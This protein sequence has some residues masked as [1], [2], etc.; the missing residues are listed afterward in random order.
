MMNTP[1][2]RLRQA[3]DRGEM[4]PFIGVYD[5]FSATIAAKHF[6]GLFLSGFSFAASHYGLPDIGFIAWRDIVDLVRRIRAVLP[7]PHL[8]VDI[9][10]G[11][12]DADTA[13]YVVRELEDAGASA[14]VL[15]DQARPRMCGHFTG[16]RLLELNHYLQKLDRVLGARRKEMVVIA[17]TDACDDA[18]RIRRVK[19]F[20]AAGADAVLADG[21]R[22]FD[23]IRAI[24]RSVSKPIMF[25]QIAGGLSPRCTLSQLRELGVRL[26]NY[27][28]PCLFAAQEAMNKAMLE[29]KATDGMLADTSRGDRVGVKACTMLMQENMHRAIGMPPIDP[30]PAPAGQE[31]RV[32]RPPLPQNAQSDTM[33]LRLARL[34]PVQRQLLEQRMKK[35]PLSTTD[36]EGEIPRVDRN[37]PMSASFAQARM[38]FL[39]QLYPGDVAYNGGNIIS[40]RGEVDVAAVQ[41]AVYRIVQRHETL[42]TGFTE[43]EGEPRIQ[44]LTSVDRPVPLVDLSHLDSEAAEREL[45][46]QAREWRDAPF[47]LEQPPL[48]RFKLVKMSPSRFD[49]IFAVHHIISDRWSIQVLV[50]ELSALYDAIRTGRMGALPELGVQY[51][52]YASWQRDELSGDGLRQ[53]LEPWCAMLLPLPEPLDLP[54]AKARPAITSTSG[55]LH[56]QFLSKALAERVRTLAGS[57]SMTPF[58]LHLAAFFSLL[59]KHTQREDLVVGVPVA[60]RN[61]PDVEALIGLFVNTLP[62]R[63]RLNANMRFKELAGQV[64]ATM[65]Q[66]LGQQDVPFEKLVHEL[67]V[68]RDRSRSPLVSVMLNYHNVPVRMPAPEGIDLRVT[69]IPREKAKLDLTLTLRDEPQGLMTEYEYNTDLFEAA[70]IERFAAQYQATLE[71]VLASPEASLSQLVA[72]L[73]EGESPGAKVSSPVDAIED[74]TSNVGPCLHELVEQQVA[75][76]PDGVAVIAG[77]VTLTYRELNERGD[78][79]ASRLR[80]LGVGPDSLVGLYMKRGAEM[81]VGLL[82]IL[83]A[84]GA[85]VPL[86]PSYPRQRLAGMMSDARLSVL[87]TQ[88]GLENDTPAAVEHTLVLDPRGDVSR[89]KGEGPIANTPPAVAPRHLAYVLFTSGSTGRPKGVMIEHRAIVNH[90]LWMNERFPLTANDRVLQKTPISFDASVWEFW[91]PLIAGAAL[92]M[93][94]PDAHRDPATLV[95]EVRNHRITTLQLVPSVLAAMLDSPGLQACESLSRVYAGGEALT[96]AIVSRFFSQC[97]AQL[98]NLY[99]PTEAA[100]DA[101]YHVCT[102][103]DADGATAP[104]G[105]PITHMRALVLD[106]NAKPVANGEVGELY[107]GGAGLARGYLYQ[108]DLTAERFV[109]DPFATQPGGRLYRT[110]DRVCAEADGTLQFRGRVDHQ[111]KLRG[112]RIELGEIEALLVSHDAIRQ[113]AAVVREDRPGDQRLFAYVVPGAGLKVDEADLRDHLAHH[114][115]A[116]VLPSAFIVLEA[117]PQLPNGKIDRAALPMPSM[118][119][120]PVATGEGTRD[121]VEQVLHEI[122]CAALG[123]E[124]AGIHDDFFASGGHSLLAMRV[125]AQIRS[126]LNAEV[127]VGRLFDAPTIAGLAAAVKEI[128]AAPVSSAAPIRRAARSFN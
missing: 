46:G 64:R 33:A 76:S 61:H 75:T 18:E 86:E 3:M 89:V 1:T 39:D 63:G 53:R 58:T 78:A 66:C 91:A 25:N 92:V 59:F 118:Q 112:M 80:G 110:G 9:D 100:I 69:D 40:L 17:R 10:D 16:K 94:E 37:S 55:A 93:A 88:P 52:D 101:T 109:P 105:K 125:L 84:G 81:V 115:P 28:T 29:I 41:Q 44:I 49:L 122:W 124:S 114:L 54:F 116:A 120:A 31:Q 99:G 13:A 30:A 96:A 121:E 73:S 90:M 107:L 98:I 57:W 95:C 127:K 113:A 85:Y 6:G 77:E 12:V 103:A 72:W 43:Y 45:L 34:S 83:K 50:S 128:R 5:V 74:A 51:V 126:R 27:S 35:E 2:T 26:V 32:E 24:A 42:R 19:A 22:S 48:C 62:V 65:M 60:G 14:V 71:A 104:I 23:S 21:L 67:K 87:L 117:M 119:I 97:G 15:E 8:V 11:Y 36:R 123:V 79:L 108:P 82:G 68:P 7:E 47:N 106:E 70:A 38:W 102:K 4:L 111:V 20:D 56:I